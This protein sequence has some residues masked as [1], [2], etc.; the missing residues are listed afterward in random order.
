MRTF[1]VSAV[2]FS[3]LTFSRAEIKDSIPLWPDGAPGAL[4]STGNDIPTLTP[5]LPDPTN[6][7]GAAMVICPGGA[8]AG[9]APHEGNDYALWLNQHGVTCFVLKYRL[10]SNGYRHP[11]MLDD[12]ARAVRMVRAHATDWKIDPHRVGIMGSS[13][14]G[15]LASTLLTHFDFGNPDS[16]DPIERQS[17][18]PDIGVL[19]YAVITMGK[20]THEGSK[21]NLLGKN[22]S[23]KLVKLLSNELQVTANTPPC[24]IWSTF[25][26]KIV[27]VENSMMFAGALREHQVPFALHIYENGGHGI[28]LAD[29]PPFAHPHPWANDC[30]FWLKEHGFVKSD[31]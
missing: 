4:G 5:Y 17:S 25:E 1:L 16:A 31:G 21:E 18:R 24:F 29:K 20:Y 26:D 15:H 2:L 9:L 19:C 3:S 14:G 10:G 30:L 6:T 23:R 22:P 28:G 8:Y 7:T 27:P 11:A 12:A 13:A